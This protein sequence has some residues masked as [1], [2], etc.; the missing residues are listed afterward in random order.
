MLFEDKSLNLLGILISGAIIACIYPVRA[1]EQHTTSYSYKRKDF[2]CEVRA[3][4]SVS[5]HYDSYVHTRS[6]N[7]WHYGAALNYYFLSILYLIS[8]LTVP[9]IRVLNSIRTANA[10]VPFTRIRWQMTRRKSAVE[11]SIWTHTLV[12]TY[13][14]KHSSTNADINEKAMM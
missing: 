2:P 5:K 13:F 10:V 12:L 3:L 8:T 6:N 9:R 4:V 1:A 11:S 7:R 14:H